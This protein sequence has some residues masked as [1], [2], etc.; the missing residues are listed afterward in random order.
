MPNLSEIHKKEIGSVIT[1]V[2]MLRHIPF[3]KVIK[4]TLLTQ[5]LSKL[6]FKRLA[7]SYNSNKIGN[8]RL[9]SFC[10]RYSATRNSL[11]NKWKEFFKTIDF[12]IPYKFA[13]I[14]TEEY[15][16]YI[17]KYKISEEI[18]ELESISY[19]LIFFC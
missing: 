8:S 9:A 7:K 12:S 13:F 15:N 10:S 1:L 16:F 19:D 2:D 3:E 18:K 6:D 4:Q 14:T 5:Y 17:N 11:L